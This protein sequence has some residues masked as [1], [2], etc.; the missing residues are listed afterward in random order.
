MPLMISKGNMKLG[1]IHNIS[2]PP[3]KTCDKI[4][5]KLCGKKC[6]A[7]KSYRQYPN[8]RKAWD[9]NWN[10]WKKD[11]R[12]F[13]RTLHS[14]LCKRVQQYFRF[15][16]GGDIPDQRYAD[17]IVLLAQMHILTSFLVYTKVPEYFEKF[18]RLPFNLHV[19]VSRWPGDQLIVPKVCAQAWLED[20]KNPDARIPKDAYRCPGS[21]ES[22][23]YCFDSKPG[24]NVVFHIH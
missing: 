12:L 3:I 2:L 5:C 8:V 24:N 19:I 7:M 9:G 10:M 18:T 15:H 6:Y 22:C 1:G 21:C 20:P 11:P 14:K 17:M 13:A 16:V 23:K 4:A